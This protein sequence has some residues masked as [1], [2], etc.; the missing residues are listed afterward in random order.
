MR[1]FT[2]PRVM[3]VAS[4]PRP[5]DRAGR[6]AE[7]FTD[8]GDPVFSTSYVFAELRRRRGRT[9]L[10]A[11]GLG[12]GVALV[13]AVT[14]L[15]Q[16]LSDAQ[17][18]V[19]EPLTGVGT[20]MTVSRPLNTSDDGNGAGAAPGN[21]FGNLSEREREQLQEENGG[22]RV[23][24][25][26]LGEPG[27]RFERDDFVTQQLS[28]SSSKQREIAEL[29]GVASAAGGLS[30][31]A[32]HVEGTVPENAGGQNQ[33]GPPGG[34]GGPGG[35]ENIDITNLTVSGV[36]QSAPELGAITRGQVSEGRYFS[37]GDKREAILSQSYAQREDLAIGDEVKLK[38]GTYEVVGI[39]SP[40]LGGAASDVYVKLDQLQRASDRAGRVNT[41][42]VRAAD[43]GQVTAVAGA[44]E[45]TLD[46][47]SVTTTADLAERVGGSLVDAKNLASSLGTA[48]AIVALAASTLIAMLLTL[49]SVSKRT[50]ELGTLK[51]IGWRQGRVVRQVS[52]ESLVQGAL[53]GVVGAVLGIGAA[54]LVSALG[55]TLQASVAAASGGGGPLGGLF[56]QGQVVAGTTDI[57]LKAPVS[58]G[59]VVLAIAL[60]IL[61]GL[62]AGSVG[63]LRAARLRPAEALRTLD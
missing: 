48:L 6:G 32:I 14:A 57:V 38:G 8:P 28:F 50:R 19:L 30:L 37:T 35:L 54:A 51:A 12:V 5:P 44:I 27:E 56:G 7:S 4:R 24:L 10:T 49:S 25:Q 45:R 3:R 52:G 2:T 22:A 11:L 53:G 46:G 21:P 17:E 58:F 18:Q 13:V 34:G 55:I 43:T 9:I 33:L 16:G 15:S 20:D 60:S 23:G 47:A 29:D 63:G 62:L 40:P 1:L 59:L 39:A 36:D 42:Y 41:V 31:S 61:A 26:N